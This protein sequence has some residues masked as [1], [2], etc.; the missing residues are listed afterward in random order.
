MSINAD[1]PSG[2]SLLYFPKAMRKLVGMTFLGASFLCAQSPDISGVWKADL[3]KSKIAGPPIKDYTAIIEQKEAVFNRRTGERAIEITETA[4]VTG[5][6]GQFRSVLAFFETDKPVMRP[7]EGIPTRLTS[8]AQSNTIT[9]NGQV[10]GWPSTFKRVY[11]LANDGRTLTVTMSASDRG[12]ERNS[13]Y[14]LLKQSDSAGEPLR[15][16]EETAGEHF[17]NVKSELKTVPKSEFIDQMR[18]IS[19]SLG[20]NCEF[21][22]V[23]DHFDSD[24]KKEKKTARKMIDMSV[25]IDRDHFEGHPDVRCFTC[26]QQQ[27]HPLSYP[28]FP[29]QVAQQQAAQN[30]SGAPSSTAK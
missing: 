7:Y 23:R 27:P 24:D 12:K 22:H 15:K 14:V 29:D 16:T 25:S 2:A 13:T 21:C 30:A 19:W 26:H 4:A 10:A 5:E 18:Y 8:E 20:K 6:H 11:D 17:K 28:L 1:R 3:E 9:V